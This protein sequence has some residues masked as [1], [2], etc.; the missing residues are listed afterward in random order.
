MPVLEVPESEIVG[1]IGDN[2]SHVWKVLLYNDD[3]HLFDEVVFQVQKATGY[4]YRRAYE[5]TMEAHTKGCAVVWAGA[6]EECLRVETI[7]REIG[8][9]TDLVA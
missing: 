5:I 8:L 6:I 2:E 7:L 9:H 3:Y 1:E 4:P